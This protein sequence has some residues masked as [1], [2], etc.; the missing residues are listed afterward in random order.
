MK[1]FLF[2]IAALAAFAL[3]SVATA[4]GPSNGAAVGAVTYPYFSGTANFDFFATGT[5]TKAVGK[6]YY[7]LTWGQPINATGSVNCYQQYGN[8][9]YLSGTWDKPIVFTGMTFQ[10]FAATVVDGH[11][12]GSPDQVYVTWSGTPWP[13]T[14]TDWLDWGLTITPPVT[15]GQVIVLP[16]ATS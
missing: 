9:A 8:Q 10:Y 4:A 12:T 6:I 13:C 15:H 11:Q 7:K 2:A 16:S 14:S 5:P 1:R 3:V